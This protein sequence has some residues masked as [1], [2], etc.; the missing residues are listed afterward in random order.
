[1]ATAIMNQHQSS[2]VWLSHRPGTA[3]KSRSGCNAA[4]LRARLSR[5]DAAVPLSEPPRASIGHVFPS[6]ILTTTNGTAYREGIH[7]Q[8]Y[9]GPYGPHRGGD[10]DSTRRRSRILRRRVD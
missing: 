2:A 10:D 6:Y 4:W 9:V 7:S 8:T 1:M 3:R 5:R